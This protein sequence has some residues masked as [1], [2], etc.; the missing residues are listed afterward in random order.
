MAE[1]VIHGKDAAVRIKTGASTYTTVKNTNEFTINVINNVAEIPVHRDDWL[2]RVAG[3]R[4]WSGTIT[5]NAK[6]ALGTGT[7]PLKSF[8]SLATIMLNGGTMSVRFPITTATLPHFSGK[9]VVTGFDHS[10]PSTDA[11]SQTI[12]FVGDGALAF[13]T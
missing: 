4:D 13:T 10:A 5:M 11:Q 6:G 2:A 12:T 8:D 7:T 1:D 9:V 3:M